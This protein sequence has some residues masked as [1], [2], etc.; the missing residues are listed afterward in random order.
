MPFITT[1]GVF[2]ERGTPAQLKSADIALPG[3]LDLRLVVTTVQGGGFNAS[4]LAA[5]Q[6]CKGHVA[7]LKY[8]RQ[9]VVTMMGS[10]G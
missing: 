8:S 7:A 1:V 5:S 3:L 4:C 9:G 2:S 10:T 6:S